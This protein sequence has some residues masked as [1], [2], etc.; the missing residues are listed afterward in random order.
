MCPR[1][2]GKYGTSKDWSRSKPFGYPLKGKKSYSEFELAV[3]MLSGGL[4][5]R[6]RKDM[7]AAL[8]SR[9]TTR[10]NVLRGLLADTT[11]A[12]KTSSPI[13]TDLN[14]LALLRKRVV[15]SKAAAQE[16]ASANRD[17]LKEKEES[18]VA[19]L[20]EYASKIDAVGEEEV[21]EA[22]EQTVDELKKEGTQLKFGAIMARVTAKGVRSYCIALAKI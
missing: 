22:V 12:S 5:D 3:E 9:D 14:L 6:Y 20:E 21:R 8:K 4:A 10:L 18:Q 11:N 19:V 7:I 13:K 2:Y 17:D 15:A 1:Y 16:F